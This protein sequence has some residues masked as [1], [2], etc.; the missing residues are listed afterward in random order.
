[1]QLKVYAKEQSKPERSWD[2]ANKG[3]GVL[4]ANVD[5]GSVYGLLFAT[6]VSLNISVT[7]LLW[8]L[9][10]R[11]YGRAHTLVAQNRNHCCLFW[12]TAVV[13]FL[14]NVVTIISE[15]VVNTVWLLQLR[16]PKVSNWAV[17]FFLA[18]V[19]Q[20]FIFLVADFVVSFLIVKV[21]HPTLEFRLPR[22]LEVIANQYCCCECCGENG[23]RQRFLQV[24]ATW[25]IMLSV[26]LIAIGG[27]PTFLWM[28]VLP[29]RML[30]VVT[31]VCGGIFT[32]ILFVTTLFSILPMTPFEPNNRPT[33][34]KYK[35]LLL[36][37]TIPFLFATIT[38][39][40]VLYFKLIATVVNTSTPTGVLVSFIPSLA[41]TVTGWFVSATIR[42]ALTTND[43][44]VEGGND[45]GNHHQMTCR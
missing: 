14:L 27:V 37:M 16:W 25:S 10:S 30:S 35:L 3:Y 29:I 40:F 19:L 17:A 18:K 15:P 2:I 21:F 7:I 4:T 5:S 20:M 28:L 24:L 13:A 33:Q 36:L 22:L 1:M 11:V 23:R 43:P 6:Y 42:E 32:A 31:L 26:H 9:S 45:T 38:L 39:L 34:S 44:P 12:A 41:L 8:G